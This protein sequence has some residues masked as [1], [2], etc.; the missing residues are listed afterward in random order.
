MDVV[1]Y[2]PSSL[3]LMVTL[4]GKHIE[5]S[6]FKPRILDDSMDINTT[7]FIGAKSIQKTTATAAAVGQTQRPLTQPQTTNSK[8][9]N[10]APPPFTNH[11]NASA[12]DQYNSTFSKVP[13]TVSQ[14]NAAPVVPTMQTP[15]PAVA[16]AATSSV[17]G[18]VTGVSSLT[19]L[20]RARQRALL[21]K[22]MTTTQGAST[23][24][25]SGP[26]P[27]KVPPTQ[28]QP[29][30][31]LNSVGAG[32]GLNVDDGV[33]RQRRYSLIQAAHQGDTSRQ[34]RRASLSRDDL[35]PVTG[36]PRNYNPAVNRP[37]G[38]SPQQISTNNNYNNSSSSVRL[39]A[40]AA[41]AVAKVF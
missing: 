11:V 32:A 22:S 12:S 18:S 27:V 21:A 7:S 25:Q 6:P 2:A 20:E 9:A 29:E 39:A 26:L 10:Q 4:Y 23:S 17:D 1:G 24:A 34:A 5:M 13:L 19:R 41:S 16:S 31:Q 40:A 28:Q 35:D 30:Q 14:L 15:A 3:M 36:L 8:A 33:R 37:Q 38:G